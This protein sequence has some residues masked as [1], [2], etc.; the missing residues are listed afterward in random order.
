MWVMSC[1]FSSGEPIT[2]VTMRY[3]LV[4]LF[5]TLANIT[6]AGEPKDATPDTKGE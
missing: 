1:I 3:F 5:L 6:K 2:E 4:L